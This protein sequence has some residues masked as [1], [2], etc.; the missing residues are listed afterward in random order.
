MSHAI[1]EAP[2]AYV[3]AAGDTVA[4]ALNEIPAGSVALRGAHT[5]TIHAFED[6][7]RGHKI[8]LIPHCAGDD[9]V[10]YGIVIARATKDIRPGTWVHLHCAE[11]RFDERSASLDPVTGAPNDTSYA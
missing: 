4:T 5:G 2:A 6:I 3:I 8:A 1:D 9:V 7:P 10:K 11:S